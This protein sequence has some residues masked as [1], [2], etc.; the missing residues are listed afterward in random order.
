TNCLDD[1]TAPTAILTSVSTSFHPRY[2]LE[3]EASIF[4]IGIYDNCSSS[5][6]FFFDNPCDNPNSRTRTFIWDFG[7][8]SE[9]GR[10]LLDIYIQDEAG[11]VTVSPAELWIQLNLNQYFTGNSCSNDIDEPIAIT[12]SGLSTGYNGKETIIVDVEWYDL[13]SFDNCD[14][15]LEFSY[16]PTTN[17]TERIF[18]SN[19]GEVG[20][21]ENQ[22]WVFDNRRNVNLSVAYI[23]I[24]NEVLCTVNCVNV[25]DETTNVSICEG[26]EYDFLGSTYTQTNTYI[27][28]QTTANGCAYNAILNLTIN[29]GEDETINAFIC[30]GEVYN[31]NENQYT[32]ANTYF[33]TQTT[34]QGCTYNTI[35]NLTVNE[36]PNET[37]NANICEGE[38]YD[39]FGNTY[40]TGGT[41][42]AQQVTTEGCEYNEILN[43]SVNERIEISLTRTICQGE[44]YQVGNNTYTETG[45]Y[46]N[47]FTTESGCD[48]IVNLDLT[49]IRPSNPGIGLIQELC[50]NDPLPSFYI[51]LPSARETIDWYDDT[52]STMP[53]L[54]GDLRFQP[55]QAGTYYAETRDLASGCTSRV[56]AVIELRVNPIEVI[57]YICITPDVDT[58]MLELAAT[59][60]NAI[61]VLPIYAPTYEISN[62]IAVSS[63][64]EVDIDSVLYKSIAGCD[65]LVINDYR[66]CPDTIRLAEEICAGDSHPFGEVVLMET[67]IYEREEQVGNCTNLYILDLEVI[68]IS[69]VPDV[70]FIVE[71]RCPN[72]ITPYPILRLAVLSDEET[73]DWY[74]APTGGTLLAEGQRTYRPAAIGTYYPEI[75][76][77][78]SNCLS[79]RR[80]AIT[81]TGLRSD[82]VAL[83][84]TLCGTM[85][86]VVGDQTFSSAGDYEVLLVNTQGC[87]SLVQL[88]LRLDNEAP[89]FS[90]CPTTITQAATSTAGV[91]IRWDVPMATDNCDDLLNVVGSH[92]PNTTFPIGTTFVQY[93]A[94]DAS[95]NRA[96]CQFA[97]N[98]TEGVTNTCRYRDSLVLVELYNTTGGENWTYD[99]TE[100]WNGR[101]R[102]S[103]PNAGNPWQL[104]QAMNTWHGIVLN[105]EGCVISIALE[106]NNLVGNIPAE[107]GNLSNLT[108]LYL[109]DNALS[110]SIPTELGNLNNLIK[111][112]LYANAL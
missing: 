86:Y 2:E 102:V 71:S 95:G 5:L 43:L 89:V 48:S 74:D 64:A 68:A 88:Q 8:D 6:E 46:T 93:T 49:V 101:A 32:E 76:H 11:N 14:D 39:F 106:K 77:I 55:T 105:N 36:V 31:F 33:I 66:I 111:L 53:V 54:S 47:F 59:C 100:Y 109:G 90:N 69:A 1:N 40:T 84:A 110:G 92:R 62:T 19:N 70:P 21:V 108:E 72:S 9:V 10:I 28:P 107:L 29:Q 56:R 37:T 18:S 25:Q 41:Y 75:R 82:T 51:P 26:E 15:V 58:S 60:E 44:G 81:V 78:S 79:D 24:N 42:F 87:D 7:N 45:E 83:Q 91:V 94:T 34:E 98:V 103:I 99:E 97:V 16:S 57:E 52:A 38:T 61:V 67:G 65:S 96:V 85:P 35:L 80:A 13:M 4:D 22:V 63:S 104:N 73:L 27:I 3:L 50:D 23:H 30:E 112:Y 12:Y 17:D 20:I